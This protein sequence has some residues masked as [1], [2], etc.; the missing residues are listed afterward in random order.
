MIDVAGCTFPENRASIVCRHVW[1]GRPVLLFVHDGDGDIQFYCGE[2][3]HSVSDALVLGLAELKD[4]LRTMDDLPT[5]T[6]GY[7]AERATIGSAWIVE[8]IEI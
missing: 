7:S 8:K 6:P 1:D 3:G 4:H 2:E 5:V